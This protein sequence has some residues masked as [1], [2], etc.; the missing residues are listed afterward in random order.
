VYSN[1]CI[2]TYF[3]TLYTV[4]RRAANKICT[5]FYVVCFFLISLWIYE[6]R[7]YKQHF[8]HGLKANAIFFFFFASV[9]EHQSLVYQSPALPKRAETFGGFDASLPAGG[10]AKRRCDATQP[11]A[12]GGVQVPP[13]LLSLDKTQQEKPIIVFCST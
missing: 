8:L 1:R 4:L 7:G 2:R 6:E 9:G 10:K 13:P 12:A 5:V 3:Y 11:E